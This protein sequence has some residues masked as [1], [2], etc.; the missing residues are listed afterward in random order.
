MVFTIRPSVVSARTDACNALEIGA[1]RWLQDCFGGGSEQRTRVVNEMCG[2]AQEALDWIGE[3][4]GHLLH[5]RAI[6]VGA[7]AGNVDL[8]GWMANLLFGRSLR[9]D[10]PGAN[11]RVVAV[12]QDQV[13][14]L[15]PTRLDR[16]EC[17]HK[18]LLPF[19]DHA[20]TVLFA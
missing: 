17:R 15:K 2:I 8:A 7:D 13:A 14:I 11:R 10:A 16:S 20:L 5:P 18:V 12:R 3:V 6:G 1:V 19:M 4:A 9:I